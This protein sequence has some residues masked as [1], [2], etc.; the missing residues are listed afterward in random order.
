MANLNEWPAVIY[1]PDEWPEVLEEVS[2]PP[3]ITPGVM[4]IEKAR[5][6][7]RRMEAILDEQREYAPPVPFGEVLRRAI[8]PEIVVEYDHLGARTVTV[9]PHGPAGP[10]VVVWMRTASDPALRT[11]LTQRAP[12]GGL[13]ALYVNDRCVWSAGNGGRA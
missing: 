13:Q 3:P 9:S 7:A 4:T 12:A 1:G 2:D 5:E 8:A 6:L 10:S 11:L